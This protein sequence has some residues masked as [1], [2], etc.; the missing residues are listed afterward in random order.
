MIVRVAALAAL[1]AP[2]VVY[3]DSAELITKYCAEC[4]VLRNRSNA[5]GG[6]NGA[7]KS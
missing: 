3:A 7:K 1:L 6:T 5:G 4:R 2:S